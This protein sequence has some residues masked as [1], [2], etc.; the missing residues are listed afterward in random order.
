MIKKKGIHPRESIVSFISPNKTLRE[1]PRTREILKF[2]SLSRILKPK[3]LSC[4]F[5]YC[6]RGKQKNRRVK[7]EIH[8]LKMK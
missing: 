2:G 5:R 6:G 4:T 7:Q 8:G 3:V 1:L